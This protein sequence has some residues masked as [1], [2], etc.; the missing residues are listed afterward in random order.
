MTRGHT[1]HAD[2]EFESPPYSVVP[3]FKV[4]LMQRKNEKEKKK[5]QTKTE[6][7][8]DWK[9]NVCYFRKVQ[10]KGVCMF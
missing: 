5:K 4:N 9:Y 10:G 7:P 8:F 2:Y 1:H 6:P 3:E